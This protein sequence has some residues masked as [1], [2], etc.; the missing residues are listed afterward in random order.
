M[1]KS[2]E[3]HVVEH[4]GFKIIVKGKKT[5]KLSIVNREKSEGYM[6]AFAKYGQIWIDCMLKG[7]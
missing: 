6:V 1:N 5:L 7:D 2:L 4:I 3:A